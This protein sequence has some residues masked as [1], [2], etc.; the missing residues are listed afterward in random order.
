MGLEVRI[1]ASRLK[2]GPQGWDMGLEAEIWAWMFG[3]WGVQ[4]RRIRR[5]RRRRR[6]SP[7]CMKAYV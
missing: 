4:R 3:G 2:F 5:R 1:W 7:M 6:K